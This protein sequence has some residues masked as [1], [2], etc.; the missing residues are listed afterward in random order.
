M[1][2]TAEAITEMTIATGESLPDVVTLTQ[3]NALSPQTMMMIGT[4]AIILGLI[5]MIIAAV[6][7]SKALKAKDA[8]SSTASA[9][10]SFSPAAAQAGDPQ[11]IA[12]ITAALMA[13]GVSGNGSGKLVVRS[14][15]RVNGASAWANAGRREQLNY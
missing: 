11:L 14:I 15:R 2:Q 12:A 6:M 7:I 13:Y 1:T 5:L 8:G 9:P 4:G 3:N 10:A